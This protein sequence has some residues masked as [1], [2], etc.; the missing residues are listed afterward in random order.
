MD[1]K[2]LEWRLP[3]V[4]VTNQVLHELSGIKINDLTFVRCANEKV[5]VSDGDSPFDSKGI[6][7]TYTHGAN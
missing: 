7:Q 4:Y 3:E 5:R 2:T 6:H 1:E